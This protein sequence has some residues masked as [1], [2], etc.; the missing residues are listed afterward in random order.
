[1]R[2]QLN[3]EL[4]PAFRQKF[5][6]GGQMAAK[7]GALVGS[8]EGRHFVTYFR[9]GSTQHLFADAGLSGDL[10]STPHD[11]IGVFNQNLNGSKVDYWQHRALT[12]TVQLRTDGSA[13]VHLGVD[14]KNGAPAWTGPGAAPRNGY[15]TPYLDTT[16]AFFLPRLAQ[17]DKVSENGVPYHPYV[18]HPHSP[19]V[20]NRKF[21]AKH[22]VLNSGQSTRLDA[23]YVVPSA[24]VRNS[25]GSLTYSL[26][27]D[28]QD[29]VIPET[30]TVS[31]VFPDGWSS[32]ALPTG[33]HAT[34]DGARWT[35]SVAKALHFQLPLEKTSAAS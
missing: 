16:M 25:D 31:V 33:W 5:F 8:A 3:A 10:S 23:S 21:F 24:S 26:D 15:Y 7:L 2:H 20:V 28:P 27:V 22:I 14:V 30:L 11:Y 29:L 13:A 32:P 17:L 12:S 18:R 4:I 9:Q 34:A 1:V 19:G 35:G 6:E